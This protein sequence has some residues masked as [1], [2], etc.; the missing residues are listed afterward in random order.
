[1]VTLTHCSCLNARRRR[2]NG[3]APRYG[4]G[5]LSGKTPAGHAPA[6][7]N[8]NQNYYGNTP[9][10]YGNNPPLDHPAPPYAPPVYTQATGNTNDGYY[11][12]Q[13]G[14]EL[15]QPSSAYQPVRAE[16]VYDAPTG[17][18]PTKK[19]DGIIR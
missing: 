3:V 8:G 1:M 14:I 16:Q 15:Q 13:S 4:T 10:N 6:Q 17:P 2:R 5:W 18:P 9:P 11:G 12:Q 19:G 7:Y